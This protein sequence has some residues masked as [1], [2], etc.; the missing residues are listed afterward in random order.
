[1][2][3]RNYFDV[4]SLNQLSNFADSEALTALNIFSDIVT[5]EF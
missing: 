5:V 4:S 1:M 2:K 3:E